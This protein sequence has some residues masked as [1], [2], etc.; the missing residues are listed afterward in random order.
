MCRAGIGVSG[1]QT[2]TKWFVSSGAI[3]RSECQFV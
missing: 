3:A 1:I 2:V